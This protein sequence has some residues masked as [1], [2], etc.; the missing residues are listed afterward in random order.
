[1]PVATVSQT[2]ERLDAFFETFH[3]MQDLSKDGIGTY[4]YR[5]TQMVLPYFP[6]F[7]NCYG[8]DSYIPIWMFLEDPMA[9]QL[10]KQ[11]PRKDRRRK[12]DPLLDQDNVKAIG[13]LDIGLDVDPMA[14]RCKQKITCNYEEILDT[15]DSIP[16][17]FEISSGTGFS[18]IRTPIIYEQY[19]GRGSHVLNPEEQ[20][21]SEEDCYDGTKISSYDGGG[22]LYA[23][24]LNDITSDN[25]IPVVFSGGSSG[26]IPRKIDFAIGYFQVNRMSFVFLC[27]VF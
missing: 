15:G 19:V 8:Y 17:W 22:G 12:Q 1:M 14:D 20:T 26:L 7:S 11:L 23:T 16:R 18:I 6:Y 27:T 4:N 25:F 5:F 24:E 10:P 13:I 3:E 21:C 9:C 2:K